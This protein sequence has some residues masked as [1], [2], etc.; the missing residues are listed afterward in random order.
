MQGDKVHPGSVV[1]FEV[2][3]L[4][5]EIDGKKLEGLVLEMQSICMIINVSL[6]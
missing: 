4:T 5:P 3:I 1:L 2:N 6:L